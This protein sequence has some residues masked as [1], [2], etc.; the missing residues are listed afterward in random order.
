M[1]NYALRINSVYPATGTFNDSVP[2]SLFLIAALAHREVKGDSIEDLRRLV[3]R[4]FRAHGYGINRLVHSRLGDGWETVI[5]DLDGISEIAIEL[6]F[7]ETKPVS[8]FS[9]YFSS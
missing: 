3:T 1:N 8:A 2:S 4:A 6:R 7:E 5:F 9:E